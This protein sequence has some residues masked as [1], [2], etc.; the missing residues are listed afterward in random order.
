MYWVA[1]NFNYHNESW[2][3]VKELRMVM[4]A[5]IGFR[6]ARGAFPS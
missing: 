2:H 5:S 6:V 4:A 3:V 1:A